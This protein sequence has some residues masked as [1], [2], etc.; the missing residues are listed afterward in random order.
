MFSE[1]RKIWRDNFFFGGNRK[2][3]LERDGY[4]CIVCGMTDEEHRK[5]W[6]RGITIDHFDGFG[7]NSKI[8]NNDMD[9]LYTMCLSCHGRKDKLRG[10][11]RKK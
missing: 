8:K 4:K 10:L 3:V 1:L 6:G 5:K 11:K 7:R 9:N 2:R